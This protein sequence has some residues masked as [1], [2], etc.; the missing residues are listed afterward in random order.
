M[1]SLTTSIVAFRDVVEIMLVVTA[2]LVALSSID[3]LVVDLLYWGRRLTRPNAFD[4]TA[5]LATMEAIPQAPIAVIIPAW[6]EHEVIFSMLAANQATTKY[7]N[8][9][10][11][12]GAYQNDAATLTEVRRAEAQSNRVHLV[13]VPR[14][15][16]T[17]KAD[18]LNVVANG[19]FAFEQAKGIQFAGLVLHDAEDLIHPYE[20][21]LFNFMAHDND[22]IQLPVFSFKRPLR[23]LVG[24]VYMDEF[25]ESHLKDIPVRRMISGLVPCAGV[26]A[27]FGRDIALRTMADNAGSLF[28]SD[29]LTE[30]YDF[31]LRLGLLGAR[32]NFV[33]APASYTIDISSSTDLPEIVG[34]KLPIA[35]REF[36]PNSFV[37]AQRQRARWLMGIVFQGTRSFGWRGTTGIKYALL[38]DR[39]SI[40]TAP[41]IM[42]A[43]LVLFGLVSVNLYFRWYL[44]DEV[45][46]FPL[47]QEPL[48]QQL[49]WLNFAFLIWRLLHRFYFTNRIYGLRHGLMSIPRL[50]LGNF[51]NFFAVAR[52]CRLYLSHSLL[53]T[54]L[55]WDKTEHQ[56]PTGLH[57]FDLGPGTKLREADSA[58]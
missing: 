50:P 37:A 33:I 28:R 51:L 22:F 23:E 21:V 3:D 42:L 36:F 49:L 46:Q 6:Q 55:V 16:P 1:G 20:L 31:A 14:D 45:N 18:C 13:V 17:S 58:K 48:V 53:G 4:A 12:V 10:L 44:P 41:L 57:A 43:Y 25:A 8:Y 47:L 9:H 5:D 56:Y 38:R 2:V 29:S 52:A 40:L 27:F 54:R 11:F 24:G 34:R 26:A 19:V 39:K 35:T 32:V 15:G 7:E 30:D